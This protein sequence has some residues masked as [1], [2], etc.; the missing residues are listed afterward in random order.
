MALGLVLL[1]C[2]RMLHSEIQHANINLWVATSL[3][4]AAW[5]LA[6]RTARARGDGHRLRCGA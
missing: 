6:R 3:A 1:L 2:L 4:G 5:N